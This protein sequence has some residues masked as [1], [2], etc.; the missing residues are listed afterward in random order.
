MKLDNTGAATAF[1][2]MDPASSDSTNY[3]WKNPMTMDENNDNVLYWS[4][5]NKIWRHNSLSSIPYNNSNDKSNF[6]WDFFSDSLHC[7]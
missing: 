7:G 5:R 4:E 1:Q 6:G 2:R 3:R